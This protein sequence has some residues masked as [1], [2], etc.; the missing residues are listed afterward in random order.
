M[1]WWLRSFDR[2][3]ALIAR[4][5]DLNEAWRVMPRAYP[6]DSEMLDRLS[7]MFGLHLDQSREDWFVEYNGD[8]PPPE[9]G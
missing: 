3:T 8:P 5:I 2:D 6:L 9:S 1:S 4:E 7:Q